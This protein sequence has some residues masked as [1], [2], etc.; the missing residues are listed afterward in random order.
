MEDADTGDRFL[1]YQTAGGVGVELQL[2]DQTF[3]A[4]QRQRAEAFGVTPQNV[5]IHLGSKFP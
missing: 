1:I 5:T 3:W 2:A 4:T